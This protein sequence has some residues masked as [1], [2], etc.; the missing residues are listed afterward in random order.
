MKARKTATQPAPDVD[1]VFRARCGNIGAPVFADAIRM[2]LR[3]E[4]IDEAVISCAIVGD[5]EI[6]SLNRRFLRHDYPTD[7]IT[8][9]LEE[10]PLEAELVISADTARRQAREYR[11]PMQ[12]ECVR[13]AIHGVLHLCGFDDMTEKDRVAMKAREEFYLDQYRKS[14]RTPR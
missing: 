7:I 14:D 5:T 3:G 9:P 12:E 6:H 1:V 11:V 8:F 13:L 2:V 4:G 10:S